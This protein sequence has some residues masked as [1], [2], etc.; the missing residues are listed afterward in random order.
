M[1]NDP[2]PG[3]G[4][5]LR[6]ARILAG[7]RQADLGA[8][9][10]Y[11]ASAI[12][13]IEHGHH[14]PDLPTAAA[15]AR[16]LNIPL[17]HLGLAATHPTPGA[18]TVTEHAT[19]ESDPMRRRDLLTGAIGISAG[20]L[21]A[22]APTASGQDPAAVLERAMFQPQPAAPIPLP[23]LQAD[24]VAARTAFRG[25]HYGHLTAALPGLLATATATRDAATGTAR[26]DAGA[27]LARAYTLATELA[28]KQHQDIAWA[29]GDR[30]LT[31][32][33]ESG[34]PIAIGEAARVLSVAMRRTGRYTAATELLQHTALTL[35]ADHGRPAP[36][37]LAAYGSLLLTGAYTAAQAH[38]PAAAIQFAEEAEEAAT[39]LTAAST[40]VAGEFG[41]AQCALFRVGIHHHLGQHGQA[42]AHAD[43]LRAEQLPTVERRARYCTDVARA[44]HAYG[45]PDRA[46]AAL[47]TAELHAPEEVRRPSLRALTA[48]LLYQPGD[49]PGLREFAERTGAVPA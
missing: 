49:I 47:R 26:D 31:A 30:A 36:T 21:A 17:E 40:P 42:L 3:I 15:L 28:I 37:T 45:R 14:T 11:S 41:T 24:L 29:T 27:I 39:R 38:H 35:G 2:L 25:A 48:E 43:R 23:R 18:G 20:L 9:I 8:A 19:R 22:P 7:L 46:Y 34:D 33:R 44:W 10:G 13:R 4:A 12:S 16:I 5:T 6:A 1:R 32:A